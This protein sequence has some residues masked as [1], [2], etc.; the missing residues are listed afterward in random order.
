MNK[1]KFETYESIRQ[2]GL[3]NMFDVKKVIELSNNTL[4]HDDCL[5]IMRNYS[6]YSEEWSE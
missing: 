5:D 2:S 4:T 6:K 3:T 1:E